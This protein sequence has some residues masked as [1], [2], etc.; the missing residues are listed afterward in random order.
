MARGTE[1]ARGDELAG[2]SLGDDELAA[3]DA[4][5]RGEDRLEIRGWTWPF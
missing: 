1:T 2:G 4:Y 3:I 5:R